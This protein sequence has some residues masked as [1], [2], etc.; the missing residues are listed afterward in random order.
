MILFLITQRMHLEQLLYCFY[1]S[2]NTEDQCG[3]AGKSR[4]AIVNSNSDNKL[5]AVRCTSCFSSIKASCLQVVRRISHSMLAECSSK[6]GGLSCSK[7]RTLLRN[8]VQAFSTHVNSLLDQGMLR[9]ACLL[10][11]G[12]AEL[13]MR[14]SGNEGPLGPCTRMRS[15]A[16]HL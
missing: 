14:S 8:G 12:H 2:S 4:Y 5:H 13:R 3:D 6:V 16:N 1:F 15:T 7:R 9:D 11:P 10:C